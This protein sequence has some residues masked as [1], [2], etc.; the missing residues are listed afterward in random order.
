MPSGDLS[1]ASQ[2][3]GTAVVYLA[4]GH[5][6]LRERV[7][8]A[9]HESFFAVEYENPRPIPDELLAEMRR[10][11]E[12]TQD[13]DLATAPIKDLETIAYEILRINDLI[14]EVW[15]DISKERRNAWYR[16]N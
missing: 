5:G 15:H 6:G 11:W 2:R 4:V 12:E 13:V 14:T 1:Y 10:F 9:V 16:L 8:K 7:T 3:F